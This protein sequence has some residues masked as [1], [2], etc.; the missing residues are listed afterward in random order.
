MI[1][2]DLVLPTGSGSNLGTTTPHMPH[3]HHWSLPTAG[4]T[5]VVCPYP[6]LRGLGA[7]T[8]GVRWH[9]SRN[10]PEIYASAP[11]GTRS[12]AIME[13]GQ[14]WRAETAESPASVDDGQLNLPRAVMP[15][16]PVADSAIT[17]RDCCPW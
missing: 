11:S 13:N 5:G 2:K 4:G 15:S 3:R 1:A 6:I 7:T 9:G 12:F 16:C 8:P 10:H 14:S 17:S